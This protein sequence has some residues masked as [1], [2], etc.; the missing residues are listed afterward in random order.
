MKVSEM[1]RADRAIRRHRL[2]GEAKGKGGRKKPGFRSPA[3]KQGH[4]RM[5]AIEAAAHS[6]GLRR[7]STRG[8]SKKAIRRVLRQIEEFA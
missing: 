8:M 6:L 3:S 2:K 1:S 5:E 7:A 4:E